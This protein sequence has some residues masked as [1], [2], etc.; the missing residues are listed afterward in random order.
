MPCVSAA[1]GRQQDGKGMLEALERGNLFVVPLDDERQWYRYHHLFADV[2]QAHL[3]AEQPELVPVLHRRASEWYEDNGSPADA[4]RHAL[5]AKDFERVADLAERAW[6]AMDNS[7]QSTAWLGWVKKLPDELLRTRPVLSFQYASALVD[8]G[9]LEAVEPRLRDA[10]R[11][12]EP[13]GDMSTWPE[14]SSDE[15]VVVDEE[16]FRTLPA[17][18]AI[19]RAN[20]AQY[21]GDVSATVKYAEL[22]LKL[23][24]EEDLL[25]RAQAA[26]LL[27]FTYWASG[28]LE[29]AH[30]AM[31]D[32]INSMRNAGN[33]VFAIASTFALADI[34]VA[35]GRLQEAARAYQQSLQLASGQDEHV[36]QVMAHL[37]L[38]LAMLYHEMGER[39]AAAQHLLKSKE[40]GEQSTLPDWPNRW[41]LARACF[42]QAK[43]YPF[44]DRKSTHLSSFV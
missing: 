2:L 28:D 37:Y 29:A 11:W 23:T 4:V 31:V 42:C 1:E 20:N 24:H 36:E 33:T 25:E 15:M 17:R 18:I 44:D 13:A 10:E 12:L 19:A 30:R 34:M 40:L 9:E 26:V 43:K 32:W 8:C 22:A 39:E 21:Q 38:G 5:A 16:L 27:G 7:F 35:Q 14:G 41:C 6:Q 3:M